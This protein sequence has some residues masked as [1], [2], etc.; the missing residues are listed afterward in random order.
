MNV[1]IHTYFPIID[2]APSVAQECMM[3]LSGIPFSLKELL[4]SFDNTF[5]C[6][7]FVSDMIVGQLSLGLVINIE[8]NNVL[9]VKPISLNGVFRY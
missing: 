3:F 7:T 1:K 6:K 4:N 2:G 8:R 5:I 9:Y